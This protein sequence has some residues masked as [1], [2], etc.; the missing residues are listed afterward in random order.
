MIWRVHDHRDFDCSGNPSSCCL[1]CHHNRE[2]LGRRGLR[3]K[4]FKNNNS[5][6]P[7]THKYTIFQEK[8]TQMIDV[9]VLVDKLNS[10][11]TVQE[12]ADFL[13]DQNVQGYQGVAESCV[14]SQWIARESGRNI[15]TAIDIK[16]WENSDTG[17]ALLEWH[18]KSEVVRSFIYAFDRGQFPEL[19][20]KYPE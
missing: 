7:K 2:D 10:F 9:S 6:P 4:V 13:H 1:G 16:V 17:G 15:T 12:V 3:P 18:G 11:G 5:P 19:I 14:I 20:G 8:G